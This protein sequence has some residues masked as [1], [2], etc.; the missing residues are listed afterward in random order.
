MARTVVPA[1][2]QGTGR[3]P[4]PGHIERLKSET[5]PV[6]DVMVN[7]S[8]PGLQMLSYLGVSIAFYPEQAYTR[9]KRRVLADQRR[10]KR[11]DPK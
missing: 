10:L 5:T 3:V 9:L 11:E 1:N 4:G 2:P 7:A 8:S 6:L